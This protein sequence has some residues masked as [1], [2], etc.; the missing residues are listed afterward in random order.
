[1]Q[2]VQ[3]KQARYDF[4]F[5]GTGLASL[6]LLMRMLDSDKLS[7]KK[8]LLIDRAPKTSNDRTWCFWEKGPGYFEQIVHHRWP[9]ISFLSEEY[10][11]D[12]AIYPYEYKMIRAID[13]YAHCL[14]RISQH[15]NVELVYAEVEDW[16]WTE[17]KELC[18]QMNGDNYSLEADLVFNSIYTPRETAGTIGLLQ[19]F[20]GW[21]IETEKP[22][23]DK[24]RAIMMDFRVHQDHGTSFAYVLPVSETRALV[25]YTLFTKAL[26]AP[27]TY[28]AELRNYI[29]SMPGIDK[30]RIVQD[31]FGVIPMTTQQFRFREKA[32][33]L[34]TAGGQT[35]GSSGYTFQFIQKNSEQ[36]IAA[37]LSNESLDNLRSSASRFRFYD[38]VLLYILYHDTLPGKKI[39]S[40]LF[41]KNAAPQVLKFLDNE[42]SLAEELKIISTLPTL[43]FLKAAIR[44][45]S[46]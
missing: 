31:E 18:L 29:G 25:E 41:R 33:N 39:F 16:K 26:L 9:H 4:V 43:P 7:H 34:G 2:P 5:L 14:N 19:H 10:S 13:L 23:F 3:F 46:N 15:D 44:V 1:M 45:I 8:I 37:L 30:Y 24:D 21:L 28:E 42:T 12:L 22:C 38:H 40:T 20:K 32:Y 35:K 27:E 17:S 11:S 6:S 36:I